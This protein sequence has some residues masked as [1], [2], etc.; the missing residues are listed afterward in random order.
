MSDAL[1]QLVS[2]TYQDQIAEL[3]HLHAG[4]ERQL[5]FAALDDNVREV[6]Q[7]DFERIQ[8]ALARDDDLFRLL[9][10]RQRTHQSGDFFGGLPLRELTKTFLSGPDARMNDLEEKLARPRVEDEDG[11]V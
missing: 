5:K 1:A 3:L 2:G 9:F 6:E 8:H 4:L 7:M 11:T 10:D